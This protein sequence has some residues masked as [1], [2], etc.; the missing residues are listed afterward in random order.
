MNWTGFRT[1]IVLGRTWTASIRGVPPSEDRRQVANLKRMEDLEAEIAKLRT[2]ES[3]KQCYK[4]DE[5]PTGTLA[6]VLKEGDPS[7]DSVH[8][9]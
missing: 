4:L 8:R 7:G 3:E 9:L 5:L 2:W 6:Y 1:A